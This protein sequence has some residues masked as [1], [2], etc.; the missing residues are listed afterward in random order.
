MNPA[1]DPEF[2]GRLLDEQGGALALYAAQWTDAADDCVQEALLELVRQPELPRNVSAWLFRVV[3]N[4]AISR[5]RAS[6][7]R[8][9]H[10]TQA[11]TSRAFNVGEERDAAFSP[12]DVAAALPTL[13]DELR[14]VVVLRV[15]GNLSFEAIAD[16]CEI[17][18]STA[19]R[20]YELGLKGLRE[21]LGVTWTIQN[22]NNR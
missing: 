16:L 21:K 19:H 5:A 1:A 2:L 4:R 20:R 9:K 11:A 13:E 6:N 18:A 8:K 3:R 10:E 15:W 22:T 12:E 7:R 14:E 17:S